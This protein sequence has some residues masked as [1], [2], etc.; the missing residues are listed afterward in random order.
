MKKVFVHF[1]V[2][3]LVEAS[4]HIYLKIILNVN[5]LIFFKYGPMSQKSETFNI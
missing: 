1:E 4:K 5:F 2:Q 3:K